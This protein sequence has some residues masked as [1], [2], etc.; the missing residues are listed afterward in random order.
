MTVTTIPTAG[1][2]DDPVGNTKLDLTA[3]YAFTGTVTGAG[4]VLKITT[5]VYEGTASTSSTSYTDIVTATHTPAAQNSRYL[6]EGRGGGVTNVSDKYLVLRCQAK[7]NSGSFATMN[8]SGG[9][10]WGSVFGANASYTTQSP[11][12]AY[13]YTPTETSS[14]TSVAFKFQFSRQNT[15]GS[16]DFGLSNFAGSGVDGGFLVTVTELIA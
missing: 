12:W 3:N 16:V 7:E 4:K 1:I 13:Y 5:A 15:S 9:N 6:V 14:L 8:V 2:A 11:S 10:T